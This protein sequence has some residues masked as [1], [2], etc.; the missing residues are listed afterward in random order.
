MRNIIFPIAVFMIIAFIFFASQLIQLTN[1]NFELMPHFQGDDML[2]NT[3]S[4][5]LKPNPRLTCLDG[6]VTLI[7]GGRLANQ[8]FEY[9][10]ACCLAEMISYRCSIPRETFESLKKVFTNISA[11]ILE[12]EVESSRC[13][14]NHISAKFVFDN[15]PKKVIDLKQ[16]QQWANQ[17]KQPVILW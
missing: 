7:P 6:V 5:P 12:D 9:A 8:I 11:S 15:G 16:Y 13:K 3:V 2:E 10:T 4:F 1:Y 17:T 14:E